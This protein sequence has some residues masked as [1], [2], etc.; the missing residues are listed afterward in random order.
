[1]TA[2]SATPLSSATAVT[3]FC[4]TRVAASDPTN[5]PTSVITQTALSSTPTRV[6]STNSSQPA[7]AVRS[8]SI[9]SNG[10]TCDSLRVN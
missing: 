1:M 6:E 2:R 4:T 7:V 3:S 5:C 8:S 10:T 9:T